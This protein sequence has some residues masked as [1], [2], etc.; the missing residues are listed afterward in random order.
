MKDVFDKEGQ[1]FGL[2]FTLGKNFEI[3]WHLVPSPLS[4]LADTFSSCNSFYY[5][6][7]S[8]SPLAF[9]EDVVIPKNLW[10]IYLSLC[11]SLH[12]PPPEAKSNSFCLNVADRTLSLNS[13]PGSND[14]ANHGD[15]FGPLK[16][17]L[18]EASSTAPPL[19]KA[20]IGVHIS[21]AF[22]AWEAASL[23]LPE[24]P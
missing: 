7:K 15:F 21:F 13:D 4:S 14:A 5:S 10:F 11:D 22:K 19:K 6:L 9:I 16:R 18:D 8:N 20:K 24:Q 1:G 23:T 17:I 3:D 12:P 2:F